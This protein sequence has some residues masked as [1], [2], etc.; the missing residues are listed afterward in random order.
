[1]RRIV[2]VSASVALA[3]GLLFFGSYAG[4]TDDMNKAQAQ[5][6]TTAAAQ[7]N[8][9]FIVTDDMRK[10]DMKYMPK[11]QS[12][13]REQGMGFRN[14]FV[15]NALCCPARATIMRG[16]YSHNNGVWSNSSTDST[17]TTSGGWQ[18]YQD[19]DNEADNVATRLDAAG[20]RTGLFGKY[21]NG[22]ANTAFQPRGWD[23]W[24][25]TFSD[26]DPHYFNY[27][28]NDQGTIRHFGTNDSD[29]KTDVI[30]THTN[31]FISNSAEAGTPFFAYVAPIAP[32][33]PATPAPRHVHAY[34][35]EK[36]PRLSSFN[37][38]DVSDK[39]S[40]I[41]QL[42]RLTSEQIA[43]VDDRHEKRVESLQAVDDLV[44]GVINT[45]NRTTPDGANPLDNTYIFFTSDNGFFHGEHRIPRQ[46]W[47]PYEEDIQVP[48]VVRGP[49]VAAGST[50]YRLTLNTDYLSTFADLAGAQIPS[51][52]D[53]RSLVPVLHES[54]TSW[55]NAILLEAAANYSPAYR[56]IRTVNTSTIA[57][58]KYV[59]YSGG[60]RELYN[61]E[62]DDF[63]LANRY[64]AAAPPE[65]LAARLQELKSC[66]ANAAVTCRAA[67]DGL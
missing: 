32:H 56:G 6:V 53:G 14:A 18:A 40:W 36:A 65:A 47:R 67:E 28:V 12:L 38:V 5:T 4:T 23:R 42:P 9:V 61:L 16:Q 25:A 26:G 37:E 46:K 31:A 50:T 33:E 19:N 10:D 57:R 20:Y 29:Y 49:G 52:V 30:S 7:P 22:Y 63:E 1:M 15:S 55:R 11:T 34:D 3:V 62:S 66:G 60:A 8:I 48:L 58:R 41:R 35:G 24:F 27:D 21:M 45:L 17:S 43:A 54:V 59:E 39:P 13:I 2:L 51:Y 64:E 44:A